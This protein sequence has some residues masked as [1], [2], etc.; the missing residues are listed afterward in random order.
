MPSPSATE[1]IRLADL[2][3]AECLREHTRWSARGVVDERGGTLRTMSGTRFPA[4]MFNAVFCLYET[5]S[6]P[7]AW[8][9][10]Q[11]AHYAAAQRGCTIYTRDKVDQG[12]AEACT[13]AGL[14]AAGRSPVMVC[15]GSVREPDPDPRLTLDFVQSADVLTSWIEC[16]AS[17]F[18]SLGMQ[19]KA[20]LDLMPTPE[21]M[22]GPHALYLLARYAGEPVGGAM[23]LLSHGI[24]G[25]YW[26]GVRPELRSHGIGEALTATITNAALA[27]GARAVVLQA[28]HMGQPVYRSLGFREITNYPWF[29]AG[30]SRPP[31]GGLP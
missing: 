29:V 22:L 17:A 23:A 28:S 9:E 4:G 7:T 21:R 26:V 3:F 30:R 6:D 27:R 15:D 10:E 16:Q 2:N 31:A 24:A 14:S 13:R 11:L 1:L 19:E 18:T 8:L 5:P 12:L 20:V 25:L